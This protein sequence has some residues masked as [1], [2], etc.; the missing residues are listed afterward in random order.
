M[1][2]MNSIEKEIIPRYPPS[3]DFTKRRKVAQNDEAALVSMRIPHN[4]NC[5]VHLTRCPHMYSPT[6]TSRADKFLVNAIV[7]ATNPKIPRTV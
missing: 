6:I 4:G 7:H 5:A 2:A 1:L 3:M